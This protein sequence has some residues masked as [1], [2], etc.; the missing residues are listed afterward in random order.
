MNRIY[1]PLISTLFVCVS[2][3]NF[4]CLAHVIFQVLNMQQK[5]ASQSVVSMHS[6][7]HPPATFKQYAH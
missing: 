5:N 4:S 2:I 3:C 1:I 6:I 7:S